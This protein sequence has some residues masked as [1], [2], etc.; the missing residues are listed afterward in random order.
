MFV[1]RNTPR[2]LI[3]TAALLSILPGSLAALG[4][5]AGASIG[6]VSAGVGASVGGGG[7]SAG[8]GA[9]VGN[10]V[11]AGASASVGDS[12]D[13]GVSIGIG[14]TSTHPTGAVAT[15][16]PGVLSPQPGSTSSPVLIALIGMTVLSSDNVPLGRVLAAEQRG[17]GTTML[18]I[19]IFDHIR[20]D[21]KTARLVLAEMPRHDSQV[22]I[23]MSAKRFVAM[24]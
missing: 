17:D 18:R 13:V 20:S 16:Q 8:V 19:S 5:G 15:T 11:E 3:A 7:V 23:N 10:S 14:G 2:A 12:T 21:S 6:G 4:L 1:T 9:S 24:I 22:H